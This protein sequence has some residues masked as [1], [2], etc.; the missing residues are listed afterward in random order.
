MSDLRKNI[1]DALGDKFGREK[2]DELLESMLELKKSARGWCKHCNGAVMVEINDSKAVS[3]ILKEM[4]AE[5]WGRP[6]DD[7]QDAEGTTLIRK[8]FYSGAEEAAT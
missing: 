3:T 6:Q 7:K 2:L 1:G 8:T 5:A 4:N